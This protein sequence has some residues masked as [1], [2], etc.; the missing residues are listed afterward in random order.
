LNSSIE[1]EKHKALI[2]F[3]TSTV[4]QG[5][6]F[7]G[8]L[9]EAAKSKIACTL[10]YQSFKENEVKQYSI[11]PLL[12]KEYLNRW[13]LVAFVPERDK[14]LTF[15]LERM[16][17]IE[18]SKTKFTVPKGFSPETFFQYSMGISES[19]GKP[20]KIELR[21]SAVAAK[22]VETQPLHSSQKKL[23]ESKEGTVFQFELHPCQELY[24]FILSYGN[25]VEVLKP[26]S[27]RKEILRRLDLAM[28]NYK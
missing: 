28:K 11:H 23:K 9:L 17:S 14:I 5:N 6:E 25:E 8:P 20:E 15:G 27:L 7:L 4:S 3:E 13:Y 1:E 24:N 18:T 10:F 19:T 21:F 26:S 2:Q 12:L 16:I 22:L